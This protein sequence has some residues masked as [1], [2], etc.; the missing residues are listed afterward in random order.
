MHL[1]HSAA[2]GLVLLAACAPPDEGRP[3]PLA[4]QY[5]R[6]VAAEDARPADGR[7]LETLIA[8][9]DHA[10]PLLRRTAIRA[11]GRLENP[12]LVEEI[13]RHLDD[14]DLEVRGQAADA[15]AQ[16]V[17]GQDGAAAL[18]LLRDRVAT[19]SDPAVLGV[20]A[21]SIARLDVGEA[22]RSEVLE[23]LLDLARQGEADAPVAQLSGVMLGIE[24]LTRTGVPLTGRARARLENL[25][26]YDLIERTREPQS[27][28]VRALA[29]MAL[30]HAG[31]LAVD[32]IEPA[33]RDPSSRVRLVAAQNLG[34]VSPTART[35]LIR[36]SLGDPLPGVRISAVRQILADGP[37]AIT[38]DWLVQ[39]ATRDET[40]A[41][42]LTAIDVLGEM[43]CPDAEAQRRTLL[44]AASALG[45]ETVDDWQV[46]AHALVALA[47]FDPTLAERLLPTFV[48]HDNSFVRAY[49]LRAADAL[50]RVDLVRD[51]TRDP[52]ANVRTLALQ[53][54]AAR[55]A[56]DG[57]TLLAQ[58]DGNDPQ[59]LLTVARLLQGSDAGLAAA[60]ASLD[61]FE[62]ISRARRE[63]WR[64]AR[65][66]LLTRI[67]ELGDRTLV[68][69]LEPYLS[70]YDALVAGDVART[71]RGWTGS[72]YSPDP[73][74]LYASALPSVAELR[75]LERT[76][77]VLHMRRGGEIWIRPLPYLALT[78]A[79]RFVR[80]A[81][82]GYLDG[83]TF[84]RWVPNFVIQGGSPG[85]NEYAGDGPYTRDEIGTF[86]HWRGTVGLSTR[87]R[88]TGDGQIF[89]NLVDN[90]RLNYDYTIHSIVVDGIE[91][92]DD[93][94]EGDVIERAEVRIEG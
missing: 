41:G 42:R 52:H 15:L 19:E 17:H 60:S 3:D 94:V 69:R 36:R 8:A 75:D 18:L 51:M 83:L 45:P 16:A 22:T 35:E 63:T 30:S 73:R 78:N 58:L 33:L 67:G 64:D 74:P 21:T 23:T 39:V 48:G 65:R 62:R 49:G 56:L 71:L 24:Q 13:A 77:V 66:A 1:R 27:G 32:Q 11:L 76:Y 80:H 29:L 82:E 31:A 90:M 7:D 53:R 12:E 46:P 34:T 68:D 89:I 26:F 84:H 25:S 85:A 61:A 87:G 5:L 50:G 20:L 54:L 86:P 10:H 72:A 2:F 14:A 81:G 47:D 57:Q 92:V 38:C 40:R 70:D 9:T 6:I 43:R 28:Q 91:V 79:H 44:G 37:D 55:G 4:T 88:D 59:L 93:V